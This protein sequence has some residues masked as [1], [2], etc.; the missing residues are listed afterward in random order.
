MEKENDV[1]FG[2]T[3]CFGEKEMALGKKGNIPF[4]KEEKRGVGGNYLNIR[5]DRE[6]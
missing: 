4:H 5:N 6:G 3:E 2:E 1:N